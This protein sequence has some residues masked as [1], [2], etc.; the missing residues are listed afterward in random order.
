MK[1]DEIVARVETAEQLADHFEQ[2]RPQR[3]P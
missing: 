1:Y 2:V 3:A